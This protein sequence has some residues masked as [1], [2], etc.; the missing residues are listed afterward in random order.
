M[1]AP[2]FDGA[3]STS[4]TLEAESVWLD[5]WV[6]KQLLATGGVVVPRGRCVKT[7]ALVSAAS[8]LTYPLVLKAVH[9]DL[10]HKSDV[11]AVKVGIRDSL[12][13]TQAAKSCAK[14]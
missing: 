12:E 5:E 11:G 2:R 4:N 9:P 1:F 6:G 7:E 3:R 13:L 14:Q 10:K 8:E